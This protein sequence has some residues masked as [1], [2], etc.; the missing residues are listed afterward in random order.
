MIKGLLP[1]ELPTR[2]RLS[3]LGFRVNQA[4]SMKG[5]GARLW[6]NLEALRGRH[7]GDNSRGSIGSCPAILVATASMEPTTGFTGREIVLYGT[8][9]VEETDHEDDVVEFDLDD[10]ADDSE[11]KVL[12]MAHYFSG[13]KF[14]ARGLF[15]VMRIAWGLLL[16]K[17]VQVM[18]D[19]RFLIEF[20]SEEVKQRVVDGGPWRHKEDAL[21]VV[22]YDVV[23]PLST[24]VINTVGLWVR[25]YD[26]PAA[27]RKDDYVHMLGMRL[28][29]VQKIDLGFSSY[30]R[31]RVLFP[32]A[33]AL[34]PE[35]KIRIKGKGDMK[36][37]IRY[38]NVPYFCF[39]CGRMGHSDKECPNGEL[40]EGTFNY[41]VELRAS[42][43]KHLR[44]I[45]VKATPTAARFLN[46]EGSQWLGSKMK[47]LHL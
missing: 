12:A 45:K 43:P 25:L 4:Y 28:G 11:M 47:H 24:V 31:V 36:I 14:N 18:G 3:E 41:G 37:P 7:V 32:L 21:L 15:E 10:N 29:K 34:I 26:L 27:L 5:D 6:I 42:P 22:P 1:K 16:L 35:V 20:D 23:P 40:G 44:E 17:P 13:K 39:I 8:V 33:N 30:V 2:S 9:H 46:F 19:N 38:E